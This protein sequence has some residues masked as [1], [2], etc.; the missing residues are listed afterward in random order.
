ME[1]AA[2]NIQQT[3]DQIVQETA[4]VDMHTHL[5]PSSFGSML[6]WG[7]DELLTYHYIVAEVM[8]VAP[9]SYKTF[10]GMSKTEQADYIWKHMFLDRAPISEA[11][12]GVVTVIQS[13]GFDPSERRLDVIRDFFHRQ[14]VESYV[15]TVFER[16]H[17]SYAVM[18]NDPFDSNERAIWEN[19]FQ[20]HPRFQAALRMDPLLMSWD[21][22]SAQLREMGYKVGGAF[23][24]SS[25]KHVRQF[26]EDWANRMNPRYMAVSL[27]P[28]FAYPD[29]SIRTRIID[30]CILPFA[31]ERNLPFA[32]MIGVKKL[33][34]PDL[35]LAG[36]SLGRANLE[37]LEN[38]CLKNPENRFLV[39]LLSRENQHELCVIARKFS[40]LLPFGCW[41]FMN[42]PS[43]IDEITRERFELLGW[44]FIPQHSDARVLDQLLYKWRHSRRLIA[45]VLADKYR[46][47]LQGGWRV[48]EEE[49][50]RDVKRLFQ[51]NFE[52]FAPG[53]S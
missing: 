38:L 27:P 24:D 35:Q 33:I 18:T 11:C 9:I 31:R 46:D 22:A 10:W 44:S 3:V 19:G 32:L 29:D 36:D 25:I 2:L 40:N 51:G 13:L 8:R 45:G 41:W 50:R 20:N 5:Y 48:T 14:S 6:L 12:R 34:N 15:E 53:N 4:M 23:N 16:A 17:V 42:N 30:S 43:I 52:A 47:L 49:I 1:A 7:V 37:C 21:S 28:T 39:T 26:L